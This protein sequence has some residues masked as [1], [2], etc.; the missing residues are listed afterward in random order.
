[1]RAGGAG[2]R[3]PADVAM[4]QATDFGNLHDPAR[5]GELNGP[6]V[7]RIR[8]EREMSASPVKVR[9]VAGQDAA[10]VPFAENENV[11]QTLA[12]DRAGRAAPRRGS[13]TGCEARREHFVDS[14]AV[15]A[16]PEHVTVDRVAISEEGQRHAPVAK[17]G[18]AG[19]PQ[20]RAAVVAHDLLALVDDAA[21]V[22]SEQAAGAHR[23][24]V[25]PRI[26]PVAARHH[27]IMSGRDFGAS[28]RRHHRPPA[29]CSTGFGS[30]SQGPSYL[31]VAPE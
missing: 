17:L 18:Q 2:L 24:Q 10:E 11:I 31:E 23:V 12:P 27:T 6:D 21:A 5:L 22:A 16:L 15:H 14:H 9:E 20:R 30:K 1:M 13:A 25:P 7:R 29:P 8:V 4:M 28:R 3:R 26:H 19:D